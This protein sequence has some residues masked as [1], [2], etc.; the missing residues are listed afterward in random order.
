MEHAGD[1][2]RDQSPDA[3]YADL[4][5]MGRILAMAGTDTSRKVPPLGEIPAL[6]KLAKAGLNLGQGRDFLE[7]AKEEVEA[8]QR[9][10]ST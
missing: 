9:L 5:C 7:A 4:V 10:L 1:W 8:A 3:D 6:A 2:Y